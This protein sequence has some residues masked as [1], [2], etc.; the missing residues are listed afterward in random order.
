MEKRKKNKRRKNSNHGF[1]SFYVLMRFD[2]CLKKRTYVLEKKKA[3][4][5]E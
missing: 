3:T 1:F 5:Q 4:H 2:I